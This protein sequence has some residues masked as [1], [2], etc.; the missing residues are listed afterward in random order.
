V[1]VFKRRIEANCP[2]PTDE[3]LDIKY[4]LE[5]PFVHEPIDLSLN[6]GKVQYLGDNRY[7]KLSMN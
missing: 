4:A 6:D 2:H 3:L 5:K 1:Q 7:E